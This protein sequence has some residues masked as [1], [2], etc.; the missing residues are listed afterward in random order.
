MRCNPLKEKHRSQNF[1]CRVTASDSPGN[2][3]FWTLHQSD[4][5]IEIL[6]VFCVFMNEPYLP[7]PYLDSRAAVIGDLP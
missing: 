7:P 3:L 5:H 1:D 6:N 2:R 4:L